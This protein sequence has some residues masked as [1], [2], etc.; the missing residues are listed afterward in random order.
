MNNE[1]QESSVPKVEPKVEPHAAPKLDLEAMPETQLPAAIDMERQTVRE[2]SNALMRMFNYSASL[3]ERT[4]RSAGALA[5]GLVRESANW[6]VPSAFRNSK[7][8]SI[9][10]Q[11]MLDFVVNDIGGVRRA[12]SGNREELNQDQVFLARKTVGNLLDMTAL[13][14]FHLSPLTVLAIFSDMAYGSKV[15]MEQL[16]ARLKEHGIIDEQTTID[17]AAQLLAALEKASGNAV[18]MFD[19]PPISIEGMRKTIQ[20]TQAAIEEVDPTQ[21]LPFAEI[22]QLWRQMELAAKD[23]NASIWDVSATMSVVAL[24]N[25][26]AVGKGTAVSLEIAGNMFS[27]HIVS[28]YWDALRAIE[29]EGLIPTL[30]KSSEPYLEAVWTNF[31]IDRKTW[32]EQLLSGEL[33]K[34]GWS[35]LSWPKLSRP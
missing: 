29:R 34:W 17:G 32:T 14:T 24:N 18:G 16:S 5:G 33:L 15:Y 23:Q 7:S 27:T 21:L 22:D 20:E 19:Q 8:Y 1:T 4:L 30:S 25:I 12:M 10:V 31:T 28:H 26:Q 9:F 11:Q 2:A 13:A 3:P 35:Q 6:L